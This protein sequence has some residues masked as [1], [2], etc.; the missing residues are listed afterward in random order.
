MNKYFIDTLKSLSIHKVGHK[1]NE[2]GMILSKESIQIDNDIK[3]ILIDY[4]I[5]SFKSDEYYNFYHDID[6]RM[7]EAYT[8]ISEIFTN[9]NTLINQSINLAKHL[10]EQ[11]VHP[12][13]KGGEF[14][15]AYFENCIINGESVDAIGLFK[16]ENKDIFLKVYPAGIRFE[17]ESE[18]GINI[19]KLD[20]DEYS[21]T[22]NI[23]NLYKN[24]IKNELPQQFEISKADQI[25]LLNKSLKFF[26]EKDN[27]D[28]DDFANEVIGH[29]EMVE[30]FGKYKETFQQNN[31]IEISESFTI[32]ENAVKKQSRSLKS[33]IKLE[34]NFDIHIHGNRSLI[35]QGVDEKG[36]YYKV[37][38]QEE[39]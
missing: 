3:S 28:F 4:F 9:P 23:L 31:N 32:S 12:R 36:K 33:G 38:Y 16:S 27:F 29:P 1:T 39:S 20:K 30:S 2:E 5:N 22:Q 10:Y 24:F 11:S 26:K 37:Y 17:I 18:K 15:T 21:N 6:I 8:C 13:I 34:K 35:E 14:Y 25:E 19:N 7:N